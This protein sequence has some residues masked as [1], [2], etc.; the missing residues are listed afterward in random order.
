MNMNKWHESGIRTN[1]I[2]EMDY[3]ERFPLG[4]YGQVYI[5][6]ERFE[7]QNL[8]M[9]YFLCFPQRPCFQTLPKDLEFLEEGELGRWSSWA[10]CGRQGITPAEIL[11]NQCYHLLEARWNP[12]WGQ[13]GTGLNAT[14]FPMTHGKLCRHYSGASENIL[15]EG[16]ATHSPGGGRGRGA[17]QRHHLLDGQPELEPVQGIADANFSLDLCVR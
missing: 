6:L 2:T 8:Q 12:L 14:L 7:G 3:S 5:L 4:L 13:E 1:P 16:E 9:P 17:G 10:V 15:G 11:L